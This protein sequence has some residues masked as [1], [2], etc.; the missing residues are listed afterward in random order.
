M[1]ESQMKNPVAE[2]AQKRRQQW[3][4]ERLSG[5]RLHVEDGLITK[6][7]AAEKGLPAYST[8]THAI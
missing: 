8:G 2:R 3:E 5:L 6:E 4:A 7:E 1:F